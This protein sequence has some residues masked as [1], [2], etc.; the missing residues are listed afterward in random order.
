ML[1]KIPHFNNETIDRCTSHK[2]SGDDDEPIESID[3]ILTLDD[4][5]RNMLL[6]ALENN[7]GHNY[8]LKQLSYHRYITQNYA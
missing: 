8:V 4:D 7:D 6:N 1:L 5:V 2:G 3:D